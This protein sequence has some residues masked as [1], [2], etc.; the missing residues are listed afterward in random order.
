MNPHSVML[1][2]VLF[3]LQPEPENVEIDTLSRQ[4]KYST[5]MQRV[6]GRQ[7]SVL[8]HI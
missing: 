5:E 8:I 7:R 3:V 4:Q 6:K 1:F 2:P